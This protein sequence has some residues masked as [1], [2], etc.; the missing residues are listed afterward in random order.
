MRASTNEERLEAH[1][2]EIETIAERDGLQAAINYANTLI[3][4]SVGIVG[5][6]GGYYPRYNPDGSDPFNP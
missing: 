5:G 6:D 3:D 4:T 2:V 1:R